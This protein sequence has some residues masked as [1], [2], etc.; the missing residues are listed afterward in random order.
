MGLL[1]RT[2]DKK[3]GT[4]QQL[5]K[6]ENSAMAG[7]LSKKPTKRIPQRNFSWISAAVS[8]SHKKL[9]HNNHMYTVCGK[10][11]CQPQS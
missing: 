8:K 3:P 9:T 10:N 4:V 5:N 7:L 11:V 1:T 6:I 2:A